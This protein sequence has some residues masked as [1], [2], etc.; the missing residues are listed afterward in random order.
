MVYY[1]I[2]VDLTEQ[3][4]HKFVNAIQNNSMVSIKFT[5][6]Q[7][8]QQG[9]V[10]IVTGAQYNKL[11]SAKQSNNPVSI[12]FTKIQVQKMKEQIGNG[13]LDSIGNFFKSAANTI[14]SGANKV[15]NFITG[16]N[17][18]KDD[19]GYKNDYKPVGWKPEKKTGFDKFANK[20]SK[21]DKK[22]DN[23]FNYGGPTGTR[24]V[25]AW[26]QQKLQYND[27]GY[28]DF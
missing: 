9:D 16:S 7:L 4:K 18:P 3:Q 17:K 12:K 24:P 10:I 15:K 22:I 8:G 1:K 5:P 13:I 14:S 19:H 25:D 2:H 23:F 6:Q 20:V 28:E 27:Y 21:F 11:N 26:K